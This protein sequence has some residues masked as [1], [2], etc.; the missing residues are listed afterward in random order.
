MSLSLSCLKRLN[1]KEPLLVVVLSSVGSELN[2][3]TVRHVQ[4]YSPHCSIYTSYGTG[5][6]NLFDNQELLKLL[7]IFFILMTFTFEFKG[8]NVRRN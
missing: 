5:K 2:T 7:T 6:E 8:D 3:V 1:L 4:S